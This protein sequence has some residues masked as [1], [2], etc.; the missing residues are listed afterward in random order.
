MAPSSCLLKDIR[1]LTTGSGSLKLILYLRIQGKNFSHSLKDW[2]F[3]IISSEIQVFVNVL[4]SIYFCEAE[5]VSSAGC[6]L[7]LSAFNAFQVLFSGLKAR[8]LHFKL[9]KMTSDSNI[10]Y[11]KSKQPFFGCYLIFLSNGRIQEQIL[12]LCFN[13]VSRLLT[14][15]LFPLIRVRDG[16]VSGTMTTIAFMLSWS[17]EQHSFASVQ[18]SSCSLWLG[19]DVQL[20][21]VN[22]GS[23]AFLF[24]PL[25]S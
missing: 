21:C 19:I 4:I 11:T 13:S 5:M 24:F 7:L 2:L 12:P 10:K 9:K 15:S 8:M 1:K 25:R 17:W 18:N 23:P 22:L 20:W 14:N 16:K 6:K 3:W